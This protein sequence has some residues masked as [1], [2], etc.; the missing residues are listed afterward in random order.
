MY[1]ST[2]RFDSNAININFACLQLLSFFAFLFALFVL[3]IP[4][5]QLHC[6]AV[7]TIFDPDHILPCSN[8]S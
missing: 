3:H 8:S 7:L 1:I 4:S 2:V 5:I 6:W